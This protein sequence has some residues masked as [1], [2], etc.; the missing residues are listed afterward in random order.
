MQG[1]HK[2]YYQYIVKRL[3]RSRI[4]MLG[5]EAG[6]G[7]VL[8]FHQFSHGIHNV[9]AGVGVLVLKLFIV[10]GLVSF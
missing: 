2:A 3:D 9:I 6:L 1:P 8:T 5:A 10:R 7:Y 4:V